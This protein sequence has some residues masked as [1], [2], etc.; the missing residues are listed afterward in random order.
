MLYV[1]SDSP[2]KLGPA[3]VHPTHPGRGQVPGGLLDLRVRSRRPRDREEEGVEALGGH[4]AG[5]IPHPLQPDPDRGRRPARD[6]AGATGQP[7][8]DAPDPD[9]HHDCDVGRREL[10]ARRRCTGG[11]PAGVAVPG[12]APGGPRRDDVRRAGDDVRRAGD[13]VRRRPAAGRV[14]DLR[15][16][17]PAPAGAGIWPR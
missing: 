9:Q 13:D 4:R 14:G 16:A 8:G 1:P 11:R 17:L 6:R 15:R 12:M 7:A 10:A 5:R 3:G 2:L